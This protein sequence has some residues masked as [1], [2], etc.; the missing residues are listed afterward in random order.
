MYGSGLSCFFLVAAAT[1]GTRM[2]RLTDNPVETVNGIDHAACYSKIDDSGLNHVPILLSN[3]TKLS[4]KEIN[5]GYILVISTC[6][7]IYNN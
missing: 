5:G 3:Y 1:F 2:G 6:T 4:D 7:L